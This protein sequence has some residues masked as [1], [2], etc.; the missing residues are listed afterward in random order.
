[1]LGKLGYG[2]PQTQVTSTTYVSSVTIEELNAARE[3]QIRY[4]AT[5]VREDVLAMEEIN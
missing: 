5:L 2:S 3:A 1:L 4:R